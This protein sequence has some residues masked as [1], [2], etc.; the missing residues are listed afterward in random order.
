[1]SNDDEYS[2]EEYLHLITNY[3][4]SGWRV[5]EICDELEINRSKYYRLLKKEDRNDRILRS[6]QKYIRIDN[7]RDFELYR[8]IIVEAIT[9]IHDTEEVFQTRKLS[10]LELIQKNTQSMIDIQ[11]IK[12][13]IAYDKKEVNYKINEIIDNHSNEILTETLLERLKNNAFIIG[14]VEHLVKEKENLIVNILKRKHATNN[15]LGF[16]V[17]EDKYKDFIDILT[18]TI[19]TYFQFSNDDPEKNIGMTSK[20]TEKN[21]ELVKHYLLKYI[22]I[23]LL[24]YGIDYS[25]TLLNEYNFQKVSL[26]IDMT[27]PEEEQKDVVEAAIKELYS[28]DIAFNYSEFIGR[29]LLKEIK[30]IT[31][32]KVY[33]GRKGKRH[34]SLSE[35]VADMFYIYD[36]IKNDISYSGCARLLSDYYSE[37]EEKEYTVIG[38]TTITSLFKTISKFMIEF[39]KKYKIQP[40]S[41]SKEKAD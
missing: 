40:S 33:K 13:A 41:F 5:K 37:N 30:D 35:R 36:A 4:Q 16:M 22:Q 2:V 7:Y 9:R 39:E 18:E 27:I 26:E 14:Y 32:D 10:S 8:G 11:K 23:P 21:G 25:N 15:D 34:V 38:D 12:D 17:Y 6:D 3:R 24:S 31:F 28:K 20:F 29:T 19:N 1:M